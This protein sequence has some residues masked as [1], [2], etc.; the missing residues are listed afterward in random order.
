MSSGKR[1]AWEPE[2][3]HCTRRPNR[4]KPRRYRCTDVARIAK[5][6][7]EESSP[8]CVLAA[9]LVATGYKEPICKVMAG[10]FE[11]RDTVKDGTIRDTLDGI[12]KFVE[13]L[14][15]WVLKIPKKLLPPGM[16]SLIY[17]LVFVIGNI[18]SMIDKI[19]AQ[20]QAADELR[21]LFDEQ[22]GGVSNG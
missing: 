20:L 8:A 22:C 14:N 17:R 1:P 5:Y 3:W 12:H 18:L 15:K 4:S 11:V 10:V 21:P 6:A 13:A 7:M 9:T 16:P 2:G 19:D